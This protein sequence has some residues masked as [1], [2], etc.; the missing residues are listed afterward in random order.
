MRIYWVLLLFMMGFLCVRGASS[1]GNTAVPGQTLPS[2]TPLQSPLRGRLPA[3]LT[4]TEAFLTLDL[5]MLASARVTALN[6]QPNKGRYVLITRQELPSPDTAPVRGEQPTGA[7]SVLVYDAQ[8]GRVFPLL[9]PETEQS[10]DGSSKSQGDVVRVVWLSGTDTA[11]VITV[12]RPV[13]VSQGETTPLP[14]FRLLLLNATRHTARLLLSGSNPLTISVAP[15]LTSTP[16]GAMIATI[17]LSST[18]TTRK[19][20]RTLSPRG[21]LSEPLPGVT[22][23]EFTPE[24]WDAD[25]QIAYFLAAH[26]HNAIDTRTGQV[27]FVQNMPTSAAVPAE[28]ANPLRLL[29]S[30]ITL[31]QGTVEHLTHPLWLTAANPNDRFPVWIAPDAERPLLVAGESSVLFLSEGA[32]YQRRLRRLSRAAF[33][34]MQLSAYRDQAMNDAFAL[35][36]ALRKYADTHDGLYPA[37]SMDLST[38]LS[39]YLKDSSLLSTS[40]FVYTFV[41]GTAND[42]SILGY[43]AVP[44]NGGHAV[45]D[46]HG[47]VKLQP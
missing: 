17:A 47:N 27:T 11:V 14:I 38:L 12:F 10:A 21:V 19:E 31:R 44:S 22:T 18:G 24:G 5:Q 34:R 16:Q 7:A 33:D 43:I 9:G 30:L 26:G 13:V 2:T 20:L 15:P 29:S 25:G 36:A 32:L 28:T 8:S 46:S 45:L 42:G 35:G 1:Q 40:G 37:S 41:G 3:V 23:T 39:P 4:D 6:P